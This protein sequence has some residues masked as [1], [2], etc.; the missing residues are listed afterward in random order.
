MRFFTPAFQSRQIIESRI[1][2][3]YCACRQLQSKN[4]I[5][6]ACDGVCTVRLMAL[7]AGN[8]E[9]FYLPALHKYAMGR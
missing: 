3:A 5:L 8:I 9:E 4:T 1:C 2:F 6:S 7:R